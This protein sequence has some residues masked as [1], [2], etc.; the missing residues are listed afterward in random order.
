MTGEEYL[1]LD[2]FTFLNTAGVIAKDWQYR[3]LGFQIQQFS[4]T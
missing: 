1:K 4:R 2:I 3:W